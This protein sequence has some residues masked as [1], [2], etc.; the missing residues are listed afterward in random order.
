M[1]AALEAV[2]AEQDRSGGFTRLAG[3]NDA[4]KAAGLRALRH[5]ESADDPP[6]SNGQV[7]KEMFVDGATFVLDAPANPVA[8]WGSGQS[9]LWS[10]GEPL[11]I[12]GPTGLGKTTLAQQLVRSRLGL[13]PSLLGLPVA[14]STRRVLYLAAD[15]PAQAARSFRRMVREDDRAV[16]AERLRVWRG[17]LPAD[18]GRHPE[19]L[20]E[21]AGRA[22]ADTVVIDSL[23]DVAV[24][25]SDDEVGARVN[26]AMQLCAVDGVEVCALHH[27]RK[28]QAG[29][30]KPRHIDDVYGSTWLTAG[31]GSV[32][33]LWGEAGD[34]LVELSHLKQPAEPVGP[35]MLLH[36]H[37]NGRTVIHEGV[38]VW[39]LVRTAR[40]GVTAQDAAKALFS[41][42][43]PKPNEVEKG[44]RKLERLVRDG[45][46]T[47]LD[48]SSG[49]VSGGR[50]ARYYAAALLEEE[51]S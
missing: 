32:L 41:T 30:G 15:R 8:I 37:E 22:E 13:T 14:P 4:R 43:D 6:V 18:L 27:Q 10:A 9:V 48:G 47:R 21:L 51:A 50:S 16:L 24:K 2:V 19:T 44:R 45:L 1:A 46:A 11:L 29:G 3:L 12:N 23:K 34:P 38:D 36:D 39:E 7:P 28:G 49:G 5:G 25:L 35:W 42:Q 26:Q 33:L 31:A 40:H 20:L 17:P